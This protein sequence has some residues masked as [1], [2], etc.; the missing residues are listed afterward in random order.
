MRCI[1]AILWYM[2]HLNWHF[3]LFSRT[4]SLLCA[5]IK[6][7]NLKFHNMFFEIDLISSVPISFQ[8]LFCYFKVVITTSGLEIAK[9]W[10][11]FL[12]VESIKQHHQD[13]LYLVI[14]VLLDELFISRPI[15]L[16][17]FL[18]WMIIQFVIDNPENKT[19]SSL[20]DQQLKFEE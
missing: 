1:L 17:Q 9:A 5:Q 3:L 14:F 10:Q 19:I 6:P 16:S 11:M 4:V 15:D 13:Y 2:A 12:W 20:Y 18:Y 8:I 7:C